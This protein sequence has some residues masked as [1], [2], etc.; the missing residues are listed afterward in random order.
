MSRDYQIASQTYVLSLES[1]H[2]LEKSLSVARVLYQKNLERFKRGLVTV[3]DLKI[4]QERV[5]N[6]E[7]LSIRAWKEAHVQFSKLCFISGL[8]IE[9]GLTSLF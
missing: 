5:F 9:K 6:T 3:N 7:L 8:K 1:A 2:S 4:D